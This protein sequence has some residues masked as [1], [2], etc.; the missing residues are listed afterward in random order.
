MACTDLM[1][2]DG[3]SEVKRIVDSGIL[4]SVEEAAACADRAGCLVDAA[5]YIYDC[6]PDVVAY[7]MDIG[8][9]PNATNDDSTFFLEDGGCGHALETACAAANWATV[10]CLLDGGADPGFTRP[11]GMKLLLENLSRAPSDI[12]LALKRR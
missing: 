3:L 12:R 7:L 10:R 5:E 2:K 9:D 8:C 11:D 6:A 1:N 4:G